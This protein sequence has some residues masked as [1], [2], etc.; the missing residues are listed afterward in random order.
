L[1]YEEKKPAFNNLLSENDD[2]E[3]SKAKEPE[4]AEEKFDPKA[5][6]EKYRKK[7]KSEGKKVIQ[8]KLKKRRKVIN[9]APLILGLSE[10]LKA[11][12]DYASILKWVLRES[13]VSLKGPWMCL[14]SSDPNSEENSKIKVS[15]GDLP[16]EFLSEGF[17]L[18]EEEGFIDGY[19]VSKPYPYFVQPVDDLDSLRTFL[20]VGRV[21]D[22]QGFNEV[23]R[24]F[25]ECI[26]ESLGDWIFSIDLEDLDESEPNEEVENKEE[27][28]EGLAA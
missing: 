6:L 4:S 10:K 14:V 28:V 15:E 12:K 26:A 13:S 24:D 19:L 1:D 20:I 21:D 3:E 25:I 17:A 9:P 22:S 8:F 2:V 18:P 23:E 5:E 11:S 16:A 7:A 27:D